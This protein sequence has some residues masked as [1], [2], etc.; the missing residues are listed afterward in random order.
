MLTFLTTLPLTTARIAPWLKLNT[1][2]PRPLLDIAGT[3]ES[4]RTTL[5]A[6]L[7][8]ITELP[9]EM[10]EMLMPVL[11]SGETAV[12]LR[13]P[14]LLF[15]MSKVTL[16]FAASETSI[17]WLPWFGDPWVIVL[18]RIVTFSV[19]LSAESALIAIVR[20][21]DQEHPATVA[22]SSPSQRPA[23]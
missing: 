14:T 10:L 13:V 20:L 2:M 22:V 7:P 4:L 18:F 9:A 16:P 6:T 23:G 8:T 21:P 1:R 5:P 11:L 15:S 17:P 12:P 3:V 19:E